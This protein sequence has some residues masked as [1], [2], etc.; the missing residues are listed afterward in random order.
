MKVALEN[1]H[2]YMRLV[3]GVFY[4]FS[5]LYL[6]FADNICV[7]SDLICIPAVRDSD[8]ILDR[9]FWKGEFK[10]KINK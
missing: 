8:S 6:S 4:Q 2:L 3:K 9:M 10:I 1:W 7:I 5:N